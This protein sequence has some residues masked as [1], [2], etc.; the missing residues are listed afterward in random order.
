MGILSVQLRVAYRQR[1]ED[2]VREDQI[3]NE[4]RQRQD[5]L[6]HED[7]IRQ[8]RHRAED[9]E[10]EMFLRTL[11]LGISSKSGSERQSPTSR[12]GSE[13]VNGGHGRPGAQ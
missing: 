9:R 3:R 4:D 5:S 2:A 6:R 10:H 8:E 13:G 11:P 12:T 7:Q 1:I